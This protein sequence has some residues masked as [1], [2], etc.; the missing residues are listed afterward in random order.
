MLCLLDNCMSRYVKIDMCA[1]P[2]E[3]WVWNRMCQSFCRQNLNGF[4]KTITIFHQV[5]FL[6]L[7]LNAG[8]WRKNRNMRGTV[9]GFFAVSVSPPYSLQN[10][11][12]GMLFFFLITFWSH[13]LY[14]LIST[15]YLFTSFI[16][17]TFPPQLVFTF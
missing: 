16:F 2:I 14:S 13:V 11:S 1:L 12:S 8:M 5:K 17:Y 9:T 15:F 3:F 7:F 6:L 10:I 4:N